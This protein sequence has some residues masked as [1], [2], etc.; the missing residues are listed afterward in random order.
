MKAKF[1]QSTTLFGAS[2]VL[3]PRWGLGFVGDVAC[4]KHVAPMALSHDLRKGQFA[5]QVCASE[6]LKTAQH[7]PLVE[8]NT[9]FPTL[10]N[11]AFRGEL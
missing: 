9:P 11:R 10:Q 4:Y 6:K 1:G 5:C 7:A 3:P 2:G 8:R